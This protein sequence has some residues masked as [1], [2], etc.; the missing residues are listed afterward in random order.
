MPKKKTTLPKNFREL[1]QAGDIAALQAIYTDT[2]INAT[3][4]SRRKSHPLA[5]SGTPPAFM[6]WLLEHG[7]DANYGNTILHFAETPSLIKLLL[8]H[9]AKTLSPKTSVGKPRLTACWT[10][11]RSPTELPT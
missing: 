3:E 10:A 7:A 9:G 1:C 11:P 8:A 6:Q 5:M 2:D 4:R